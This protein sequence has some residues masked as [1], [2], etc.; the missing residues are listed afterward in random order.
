MTNQ[1][2]LLKAAVA[3]RYT[4]EGELGRGG[5]AMVY[6]AR[7]EKLGRE[8]ALKVLRPELAASL[9]SERFL[10]SSTRRLPSCDSERPRPCPRSRE[11]ANL[12]DTMREILAEVRAVRLE[13]IGRCGTKK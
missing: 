4:I 5:M 7:D 13:I 9:G 11:M 1:L 2:D 3:D 10:R 6:L 8:V 12:R